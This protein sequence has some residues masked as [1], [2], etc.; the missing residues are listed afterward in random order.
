ME[1]READG[2]RVPALGFGTWQLR[3]KTCRE[4]VRHALELGYR[5]LDTARMYR[6][7]VEVGQGLRDSGIDRSET[8]LVSKIPGSSLDRDSVRRETQASLSDLGTDYLDL[9]LIHHPSSSVP[10]AETLEAMRAEQDAGRVRHLGVSNFSS[11]LMEEA[12]DSAPILCN[13]IE[14]HPGK[15]QE[16]AIAA[17]REHG[18]LITAYSP[19]ARGALVKRGEFEQI[20]R[21]HGK[22]AGQVLLRWLLDQ[23]SVTTIPRASDA[24]HREENLDVFDFTLSEEEREQIGAM[25]V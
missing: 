9:L 10:L 15:P 12:M 7:E 25:G 6:N 2:V 22:T 19:F 20:G 23:E 14:Y 18:V 24:R 5:H 8:F 1:F 4:G 16:R 11:E 3:G 21:R 17:A 13:Q